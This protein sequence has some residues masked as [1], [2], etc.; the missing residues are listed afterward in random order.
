VGAKKRNGLAPVKP[1]GAGRWRQRF[2]GR[3]P[4]V[5]ILKCSI[6][7]TFKLTAL[8]VSRRAF[9]KQF[10]E[11]AYAFSERRRMNRFFYFLLTAVPLFFGNRIFA[12]LSGH[13]SNGAAPPPTAGLGV[14]GVVI[15]RLA[16][17]AGVGEI[18]NQEVSIL[19]LIGLIYATGIGYFTHILLGEH[20]FGP[21]LN[22][23]IAFLGGAATLAVMLVVA[24]KSVAGSVSAIVFAT[25]IG[26]TALLL[27]L[28][29]LKALVLDR[30]DSH[31]SGADAPRPARA[32]SP[33]R[34]AAV[35]A[36]RR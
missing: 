2:G 13:E 23:L 34:I 4:Q 12:A 18:S 26:S 15:R 10:D 28:C 17:F 27:A 19:S 14:H 20:S 35:T 5:E 25:I 7:Q 29:A 32:V 8:I 24:P 22:G 30:I 3:G 16:D 36:R 9:T 1:G 21:K 11:S 6:V 31:M 33:S